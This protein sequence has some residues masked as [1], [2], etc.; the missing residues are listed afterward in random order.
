MHPHR[1]F[2]TVTIAFQGEVE[3]S[4]SV[5]NTGVIRPGDVQWMTAGRGILHKEHHSRDFAKAGGTFEMAQIWVNLPR[6][7][8]M[9]PPAY[10]PILNADIPAVPLRPAPSHTPNEYPGIQNPALTVEAPIDASVQDPPA[11]VGTVRVIA[12]SFEGKA[13]PAKTTTPIEMWDVSLQ[14]AGVPV[15]L[16][17]PEGHQLMVLVRRGGLR[18]GDDDRKMGP[19]QLAT[20]GA[21]GKLRVRATEAD[22]QLLVLAG[23]PI[24]EPIA[25][26]GPFVMNER[27]EL[28]QAQQDFVLGK[29]GYD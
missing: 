6:A 23:E 9:D 25:H 8:K 7:H 18:I 2:E 21:A 10:Q 12:G 5:G 19:Q 11:K 4:D 20:F 24:D 26:M 14:A 22:T 1:G 16:P 15:E 29:L 3:H 13:G 17:V 28:M 27:E